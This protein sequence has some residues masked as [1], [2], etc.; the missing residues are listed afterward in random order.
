MILR[1]FLT[2]LLLPALIQASDLVFSQDQVLCHQSLE[3]EIGLYRDC[4]EPSLFHYIVYTKQPKKIGR[5]GQSSFKDPK[6]Y[7]KISFSINLSIAQELES[8]VIEALKSGKCQCHGKTVEVSEPKLKPLKLISA[9]SSEGNRFIRELS[10]FMQRDT[11]RDVGLAIPVVISLPASQWDKLKQ[12]TRENESFGFYYDGETNLLEKQLI[13][14]RVSFDAKKIFGRFKTHD[15]KLHV[16]FDE[17]FSILDVIYH[18]SEAMRE[19]QD[20]HVQFASDHS[21]NN[22]LIFEFLVFKVLFYFIYTY[23]GG[24]D[25]VSIINYS[26][27][28]S[29]GMIPL[30]PE[31]KLP[32]DAYIVVSDYLYLNKIFTH[33]KID[34]FRFPF[35]K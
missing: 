20:I 23:P 6:G 7:L 34:F 1:V 29:T 35:E 32:S 15:R 27:N 14:A 8:R 21:L 16:N 13:E 4:K 24:K 30:K 28:S 11:I 25:I 9:V 31:K 17:W 3:K 5:G 2:I 33:L 18:I 22:P 10:L 19:G 26:G 12:V